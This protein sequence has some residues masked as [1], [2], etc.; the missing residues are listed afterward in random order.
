MNKFSHFKV[1]YPR[2][3]RL[4]FLLCDV[5]FARCLYGR[6]ERSE[7]NSLSFCYYRQRFKKN[8]HYFLRRNFPSGNKLNIC[9]AKHIFFGIFQ[10]FHRQFLSLYA[11]FINSIL[12]ISSGI[13]VSRFQCSQNLF[14][15]VRI[16]RRAYAAIISF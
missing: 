10:C 3:A 11:S 4:F 13:Q 14:Y 8:C 1:L 15:F 5:T 12:T 6:L 7:E 2:N 16:R 9:S